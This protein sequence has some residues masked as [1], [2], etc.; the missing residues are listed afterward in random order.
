MSDQIA[1]IQRQSDALREMGDR[2]EQAIEAEEDTRA[3]QSLAHFLERVMRDQSTGELITL[4]PMHRE[5]ISHVEAHLA[6]RADLRLKYFNESHQVVQASPAARKHV[7]ILAPFGSGKSSLF[8]VGIPLFLLG[9]NPNLRILILSNSD[10]NAAKRVQ[11]IGG[12]IE[13]KS[14]AD[15]NRLFPSVAPDKDKAWSNHQL[16]V[17]R[18][19]NAMEASVEAYGINSTG[20]GSRFDV[21]IPD[22]PIDEKDATSKAIRDGRIKKF[23]ETWYSRLEPWGI[24]LYIA[25]RWHRHDLT[26]SLLT[27]PDWE[28]IVQAVR[29]DFRCIE[30]PPSSYK[31]FP[32]VKHRAL[33]RMVPFWEKWG[34]EALIAESQGTR[35]IRAFDR[36]FRQKALSDSDKTFDEANIGIMLREDLGFDDIG[37]EWPRYMGTDLS[38]EKRKGTVNFVVAVAPDKRRWICPIDRS[39][40]GWGVDAAKRFK[41]VYDI[42]QPRIALVENNAAQSAMVDWLTKLYGVDLPVKGRRTGSEKNDH[43]VGLPSINIEMGNGAWILPLKGHHISKMASCQCG[44]CV[45][46]R[47]LRDHPSTESDDCVMAMWICSMAITYKGV[48]RLPSDWVKRQL[49]ANASSSQSK[50]IFGGDRKRTFAAPMQRSY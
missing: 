27:L 1:E 29:E 33:P 19:V 50:R 26:G 34:R 41:T 48:H 45:F 9:N 32:A 2:V 11:A 46:V 24:V 7:G 38:S 18:E 44:I 31:H 30:Q 49:D 13:G 36:G 3:R 8:A 12:Y 22:D 40:A 20:I 14:S 28:F 37:D 23:K 15:Y 4:A 39:N 6:Q 35:G 43:S 16:A 47:E 42:H 10:A 21:I 5:W 25:T 17:T